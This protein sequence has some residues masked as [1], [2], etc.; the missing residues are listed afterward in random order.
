M[1][2]VEFTGPISGSFVLS[3]PGAY[4]SDACVALYERASAALTSA[5]DEDLALSD[6]RLRRYLDDAAIRLGL[7]LLRR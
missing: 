7:T 2:Y 6:L 3:A 4:D 5:A 1:C